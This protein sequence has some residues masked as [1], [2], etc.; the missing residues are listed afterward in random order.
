[1]GLERGGASLT[2]Y[3]GC[4]HDVEAPIAG[5][6]TGIL[7]LNSRVSYDD[8]TDGPA[9]TILLGEITRGSPTLGWASGTRATLRNTG[10]ALDAPDAHAPPSGSMNVYQAAYNTNDLSAVESM[11]EDGILPV[12]YVGGFLSTHPVGN[13]FL[14]ANGSVRLIKRSVDQHIYRFL[15]NRADGNLI[16]DDSF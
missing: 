7:Y 4:H 5:D 6:N 9:Y 15:G 1:M 2:N 11:V 12:D 14:F 3:A 16:S 13:N 10:H 8:I